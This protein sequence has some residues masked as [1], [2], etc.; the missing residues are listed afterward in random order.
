[1]ELQQ[2]TVQANR[3]KALYAE[4]NRNDGLKRWGATE[5]AQGFV[6]DVGD[7][8]KLMMVRDGL[9]SGE[10]AD[11]KIRHELV[12]CL[13]SVLVIADELNIDLASEFIAGMEVLESR[14]AS[15]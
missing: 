3:I 6:A 11:R 1:M 5:Y 2:L 9:R 14:I 12:D 10:A 15:G 8:L 7:L 4:Q 13:W